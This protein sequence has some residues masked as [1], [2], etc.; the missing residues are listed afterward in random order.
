[1]DARR[2]TALAFAVLTLTTGR[3]AAQAPVLATN[4][5]ALAVP[6]NLVLPGGANQCAAR[7][8]IGLGAGQIQFIPTGQTTCMWWSTQYGPDQRRRSPTPTSRAGRVE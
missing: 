6:A 7:P 3:A 8:Y 4:G 5:S 1:M 2:T